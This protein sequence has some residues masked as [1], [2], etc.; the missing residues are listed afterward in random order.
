MKRDRVPG[1]EAAAKL[2]WFYARR[3]LVVRRSAQLGFL[4]LFLTGPLLGLWI[5][6]GTLA[7]SM[8]LD[9]LPLTDPLFALQALVAGHAL[10]STALIGAGIV[11]L[12]YALIGGRMFCAWVCPVNMLTDFAHWLRGRF[13]LRTS[14]RLNRSLRYWL[15]LALLVAAGATGTVV[16][17]SMNPVTLLHRGLVFGGLFSFGLASAIVAG[18]FLFD[19]AVA[20]HGW[21]GHICPV[22]AFYGL[23]GRFRL[24]RI[25]APQRAKCDMCQDCF[26]VCPEPQI[27]VPALKAANDPAAVAAVSDCTACGRCIDVCPHQVFAYSIGGMK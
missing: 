27:L 13:G 9:V 10:A 14:I 21:C 19:L 2:G 6:K 12:A 18:V 1:A 22:G 3:W 11:L 23:I 5:T 8:T 15:I 20:E 4:A 7:S 25:V 16:W 26:A 17:E 24:V